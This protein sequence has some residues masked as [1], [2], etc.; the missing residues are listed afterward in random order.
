MKYTGKNLIPPNILHQSLIPGITKKKRQ[1]KSFSFFQKDNNSHES[2][3]RNNSSDKTN[4]SNV[5]YFQYYNSN[6]SL[7]H[8]KKNNS[9][10]IIFSKGLN[11][12]N[13]VSL[14]EI[15]LSLNKSQSCSILMNKKTFEPF[16]LIKNNKDTS[17]KLRNKVNKDILKCNALLS[18][19]KQHNKHKT[20]LSL[21][22][23]NGSIDYCSSK[24]KN[25]QSNKSIK[26]LFN[27]LSLT[28]KTLEDNNEKVQKSVSR[29]SLLNSTTPSSNSLINIKQ[30]KT[31][32]YGY[33][34]PLLLERKP[35]KKL[36]KQ[37]S[38][39]TKDSSSKLLDYFEKDLKIRR[40]NFI[41]EHRRESKEDMLNKIIL[42]FRDTLIN[43]ILPLSNLSQMFNLLVKKEMSSIYKTINVLDLEDT[44]NY[45]DNSKPLS[46]VK[47]E[48]I[49]LLYLFDKL[50]V[51]NPEHFNEYLGRK[52]NPLIKTQKTIEFNIKK[53][54]TEKSIIRCKR[55]KTENNL[56]Q[57]KENFLYIQNKI[58]LDFYNIIHKEDDESSFSSIRDNVD[59]FK[60][61]CRKA[62]SIKSL[63]SLDLLKNKNFFYW[64]KNKD[65]NKLQY[66][67]NNNDFLTQIPLMNLLNG[68]GKGNFIKARSRS[69]LKQIQ[70]KVDIFNLFTNSSSVFEALKK[71][72][73]LNELKALQD[74]IR[75]RNKEL[76]INCQDP[77]D[78]N[79]LLILSVK[80]N[81]IEI[82]KYLLDS[83]ADPNIENEYGNTALHYAFSNNY[84]KAADLLSNYGAKENVVNKLGLTP[85]ECIN[86]NCEEES[87]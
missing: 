44:I 47:V 30:K 5:T 87:E 82:S 9:N 60:M 14:S 50:F 52:S 49:L 73:K 4:A 21:Y 11:N 15:S 57:S 71:L 85:W 12:S 38:I 61:N 1:Q 22:S 78:G 27:K 32:D 8:L 43:S 75:Q 40:T 24:E 51:I 76:N 13:K 19:L 6:T 53:I 79:T 28:K 59:F 7:F 37:L 16:T 45:F 58:F 64:R 26:H 69:P 2:F 42:Q 34:S 72:V 18:L 23:P 29:G 63:Y 20:N 46:T 86:K 74:V 31:E 25:K 65:S 68:A 77:K 67:Y 84:Y 3:N 10:K 55:E 83:G 33:L 56:I 36:R 17:L 54:R 81:N 48:G 62:R 41:R 80:L 35:I 39:V 70:P 66:Y